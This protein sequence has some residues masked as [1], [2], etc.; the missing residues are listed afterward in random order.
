MS[1]VLFTLSGL[2]GEGPVRPYHGQG[3]ALPVCPPHHQAKV[4]M[5]G[6]DRDAV[7]LRWDE[8]YAMIDA[9]TF[10][11]HSHTHTHTRW[12]LSCSSANEKSDKIRHD[13]EASRQTLIEKLGGVSTHLCWP[14]GYYD[15]DYKRVAGELGFRH[16]Y[17][18][19]ARGQN[20]PK[21]DTSHIYRFA[22]RDR[23]FPWLRQRVWVATHPT[24]GPR[25][26]AWKAGRT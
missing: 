1:A 22:V 13:L 11:I 26:N 3:R 17:T 18:T 19:D 21:G 8:V 7:M 5:F 2:L 15:G 24:W 16:L 6:P 14:H 20:R 25:Y 23:S 9:G 12:D 10:E 4:E